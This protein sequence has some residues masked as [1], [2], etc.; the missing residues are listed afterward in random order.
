[1]DSKLVGVSE[2]GVWWGNMFQWHDR[3]AIQ[4]DSG[5]KAQQKH[6]CQPGTTLRSQHSW[7]TIEL[8]AASTELEISVP[9]K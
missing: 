2:T 7:R 8:L 4:Q 3:I 6:L 1:M 9:V 5:R